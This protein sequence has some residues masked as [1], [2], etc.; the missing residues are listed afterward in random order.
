MLLSL[1][2]E[3]WEGKHAKSWVENIYMEIDFLKNRNGY[4]NWNFAKFHIKV[5]LK[6]KNFQI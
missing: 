6:F 3:F 1:W 4:Q 5:F 2:E